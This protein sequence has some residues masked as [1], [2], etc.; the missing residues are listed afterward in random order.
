[1]NKTTLLLSVLMAAILSA[2]GVNNRAQSEQNKIEGDWAVSQLG[3]ADRAALT[4][5][6]MTFTLN[7]EEKRFGGKGS[8]NSYGGE[9]LT[10]DA[11]TSTI[12]FGDVIA[13]RM[14]C[15]EIGFEQTLFATLREA[16]RY[17]V[18]D[19]KCY[20]YSEKDTAPLLVLSRP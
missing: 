1:M 6:G 2:C 7:L 10:Y 5:V 3:E 20:L 9:V 11:K 14:Y 12:S 13:T 19:G 4:S 18:K 17:E 15:P 16:K 8:C